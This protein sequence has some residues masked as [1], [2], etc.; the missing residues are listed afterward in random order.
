MHCAIGNKEL[1]FQKKICVLIRH[2]NWTFSNIRTKLFLPNQNII[3]ITYVILILKNDI[4]MITTVI[5][6]FK[7][8]FISSTSIYN[9]IIFSFCERSS[10]MIRAMRSVI[11]P[12][13]S[14]TILKSQWKNC[15]RLGLDL[16][17]SYLTYIFIRF[18]YMYHQ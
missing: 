8:F 4:S 10:N 14:T 18:Y 1:E 6:C 5:K 12:S 7:Y 15:G 9:F 17:Y 2:G 13:I 16:R 3:W 11:K